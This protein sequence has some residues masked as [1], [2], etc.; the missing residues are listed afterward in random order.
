MANET[1]NL[2][3]DLFPQTWS[4]VINILMITAS[5]FGTV[6]NAKVIFIILRNKD[7]RTPLNIL[8]MNLSIADLV[9]GISIYPFV[10]V[11]VSRIDLTNSERNILCAFS[12][13]MVPFFIAA[14]ESVLTLC[15]I[16][17][18]RFIII[19][20]PMRLNLKL[21]KRRSIVFSLTT[22]AASIALLLPNAM[23]LRYEDH[24]GFCF[25]YYPIW[26][27]STLYRT[28]LLVLGTILPITTM[29]MT[30]LAAWRHLKRNTRSDLRIQIVNANSPRRKVMVMLGI[31]IVT[32]LSC[33]TPFYVY[34]TLVSASFYKDN[35]QDKIRLFRF[36]TIALLFALCNSALDPIIYTL[37]GE[38]F[39]RAMYRLW[40][41]NKVRPALFAKHAGKEEQ[42]NQFQEHDHR[43]NVSECTGQEHQSSHDHD[44]M[45]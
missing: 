29:A 16:S 41:N 44:R 14:G 12:P 34:W 18:S 42:N 4:I 24:T 10:F 3:P 20:Y 36:Y 37:S 11:D 33:W 30:Y 9:A 6:A 7:L 28:V 21:T 43:K 8:L 25:R 19:K 39:R 5:V 40:K 26:M 31:L 22:W 23:S 2:R 15:A 38:Q 27:N 13:A 17:I 1:T 35:V 45:P 32:Y